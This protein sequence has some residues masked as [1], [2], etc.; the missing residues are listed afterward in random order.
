MLR[1][2]VVAWGLCAGVPLAGA[3][4][5]AAFMREFERKNG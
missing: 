4:A 2:A 1:A 5:L 3:Q